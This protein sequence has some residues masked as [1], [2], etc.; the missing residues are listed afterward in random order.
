M[1]ELYYWPTPNGHKITLFLEETGLP[2]QIVPLDISKGGQFKPEFLA[3]S[4]NSRMPAI[5][6]R[7]RA[8]DGEAIGAFESGAILVY[9]AE[10]SHMLLPADLRGRKAAMEWLFWQVGIK[11][12]RSGAR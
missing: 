3:F 1:I 12:G 7:A 8:D 6:D 4:P 10:R 11:I 2:Y 9:L 5:I